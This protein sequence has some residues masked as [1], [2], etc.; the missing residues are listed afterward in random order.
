MK[1]GL[2]IVGEKGLNVLKN[3]NLNS[4]GF[5]VSYDDKNTNDDSYTQIQ[6]ICNENNIKY[7]DKIDFTLIPNNIEKI[8]VVGWQFLIK[9]NLKKYIVLHDSYLPEYKGWAPTI[10]YLI[11]GSKYLAVTA[12][13]PTDKVDSG[14][15]Y[16]Q[17]KINITY[18]IKINKALSIVSRLYSKTIN[19]IMSGNFEKKDLSEKY[20][21]RYESF[22]VWRDSEDY[23]IDW[24]LDSDKIKRFI[25]AVGYPYDGAKTKIDNN[26]YTI[27]ES[28]IVDDIKIN[29]REAHIGKVLFFNE[30]NPVVICGNGLIEIQKIR[31]SR[32]IDYK[33][34][35]LKTR[36]K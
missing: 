23:F 35:K 12:F 13:E 9:D 25:D 17:E 20:E 33:I 16:R 14:T 1:Y 5:V 36:F 19:E 8:F 7:Y 4:I 11:N 18:P 32:G 28:K 22:S 2:F 29:N 15:I 27:L 3:L 10:N 31:D 21:S 30:S 24:T 34:K 26:T 6:N